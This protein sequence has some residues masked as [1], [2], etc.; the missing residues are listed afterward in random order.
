MLTSMNLFMTHGFSSWEGW[1]MDP[2]RCANML[3]ITWR[4]ISRLVGYGKANVIQ[5]ISFLL[6]WCYRTESTQRI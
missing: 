2:P 1:V 5:S 6:G 4:Q 3:S